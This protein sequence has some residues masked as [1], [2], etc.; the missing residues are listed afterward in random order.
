[1]WC[2]YYSCLALCYYSTY[3]SPRKLE[4]KSVINFDFFTFVEV[5]SNCSKIFVI[6]VNF[7][8]YAYM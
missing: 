3:L 5:Q 4:K 8:N 1:M 2:M 7:Y 6:I